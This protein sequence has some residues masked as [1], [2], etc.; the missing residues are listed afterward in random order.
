MQNTTR[1]HPSPLLALALSVL[2][3]LPAVAAAAAPTDAVPRVTVRVGDL[4][5]ESR[6]GIA[7]LYQ[8]LSR[9]SRAVCASLDGRTLRERQAYE[10]CRRD[11]MERA[12]RDVGNSD[13]L[14]LHNARTAQRTTG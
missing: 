2:T 8:R 9:A 1:R 13:L 3:S 11:S 4:N 10:Q 12:V 5:L 6:A 14:A 7:A